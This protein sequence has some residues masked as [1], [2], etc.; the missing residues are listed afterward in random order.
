MTFDKYN[1]KTSSVIYPN[2]GYLYDY[3]HTEEYGW[4]RIRKEKISE[5]E[6]QEYDMKEMNKN[7]N[8]RM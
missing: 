5:L 4:I 8:N 3:I 7:E 1:H 6:E 2:D